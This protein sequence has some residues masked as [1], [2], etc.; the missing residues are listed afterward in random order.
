VARILPQKPAENP[1]SPWGWRAASFE[2]CDL[3]HRTCGAER[4]TWK[5]AGQ[6]TPLDRGTPPVTEA[7]AKAHL[8][9]E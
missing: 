5:N 2:F 6:P 1:F 3:F 4:L 9:K 7:T 8:R